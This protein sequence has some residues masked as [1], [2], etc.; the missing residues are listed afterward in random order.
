MQYN[1][2]KWLSVRDASMSAIPM[3]VVVGIIAAIVLLR[4]SRG[5]A[6]R[7]PNRSRALLSAAIAVLIMAVYGI[8]GALGVDTAGWQTPISVLAMVGMGV[9]GFFL[10]RAALRGEA[11]QLAEE[12]KRQ[13]AEYRRTRESEQSDDS[14]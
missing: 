1:Q 10:V 2:Y 4:L 6:A 7:Q 8:A 3:N 13:A 9:A 5:M 14:R 12:A 11:A